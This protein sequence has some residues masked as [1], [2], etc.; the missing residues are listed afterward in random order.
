MTT[1]LVL[2]LACA[3]SIEP[4]F[5]AD[6]APD[7]IEEMR[8]WQPKAEAGDAEAQFQLGQ[9]YALGHGFKQNFKTAAEWYAK[10]AEQG[11]AKARTALGMCYKSGIGVAKNEDTAREWFEKAAAQDNSFA[12]LIMGHLYIE[13]KDYK[14]AR[15]WIDMSIEQG[16]AI[17]MTRLGSLYQSGEGVDKNIKQAI[18]WYEK[19]ASQK[20]PSTMAMLLLSYLYSSG[21]DI[22]RDEQR[23]REWL[24]KSCEAGN[25]MAC[26]EQAE[27]YRKGR[28]GT[29]QDEKKAVAFYEKTSKLGYGSA[30]KEL[31][32]AYIDGQLG[33]K[34]DISKGLYYLEISGNLYNEKALEGLVRLYK[35]GIDTENVKISADSTKAAEWSKK[36]EEDINS[37]D[38]YF[39]YTKSRIF[40]ELNLLQQLQN[41]LQTLSS[42]R[43]LTGFGFMCGAP[44]RTP[45]K[46]TLR[47][48]GQNVGSKTL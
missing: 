47:R 9:M 4:A 21:K 20:N 15:K 44:R 8:K 5:A 45:M 29:E 22:A 2:A 16:N 10:S 32:H 28:Q 40:T 33:L 38:F 14:Q 18:Q 13:K 25:G 31:A 37:F 27:N 39:F 43:S 12:Q 19:A 1:L 48:I 41:S 24:Q 17:A 46:C 23:A 42:G 35:E 6:E 7:Y 11:N 26:Y 36:L 30:A 3:A 34:Q